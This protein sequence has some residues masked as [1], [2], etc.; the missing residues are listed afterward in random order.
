MTSK[1]IQYWGL[2]LKARATIKIGHFLCATTR[3][4]VGQSLVLVFKW[5]RKA[6]GGRMRMSFS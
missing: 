2:L 5:I 4:F 6:T 1:G 3:A